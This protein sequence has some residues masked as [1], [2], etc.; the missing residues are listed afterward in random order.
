M[1]G[2]KGFPEAVRFAAGNGSG[3]WLP[4]HLTRCA[5][6]MRFDAFNGNNHGNSYEKRP[7]AAAQAAHLTQFATTIRFSSEKV[8]LDGGAESRGRVLY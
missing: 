8:T 2:F 1:R 7:P 6:T 3:H 5:E 4:R